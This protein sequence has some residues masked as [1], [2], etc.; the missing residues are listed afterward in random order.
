MCIAAAQTL[1]ACAEKKG[2]S[3]DYLIPTMDEAWVYPEVATAVGMKA[4]EQGVARKTMTREE[5]HAMATEKIE[6]AHNM[7][8]CLTDNKFIKL[9]E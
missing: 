5:L 6:Y 4:I 7:T 8:Q 1:S 3:E 9:P 2:L